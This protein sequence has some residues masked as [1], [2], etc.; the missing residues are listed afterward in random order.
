MSFVVIPVTT[1]RTTKSSIG[2]SPFALGNTEGGEVA[3]F[4]RTGKLSFDFM[5]YLQMISDN[6]ADFDLAFLA[7]K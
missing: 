6:G 4:S 3:L 2:V 5:T 1:T 7:R